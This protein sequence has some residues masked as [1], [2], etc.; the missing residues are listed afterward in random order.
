M[1]R[2][3]AAST[4]IGLAA[5]SA[6]P[7]AAADPGPMYFDEPGHY[8]NDVP[9]MIYDAHLTAPCTNMG[10][11]TFG[12]GPGGEALQCRW[13]PNQWPPVYTGFW[14]ATYDLK[15]V[16]DIGAQC[17]S[18]QSA[19]QAPDGRPLVC[20]GEQGWRAGIYNREG[21]TPIN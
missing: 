4:L 20:M 15:G 7:V 19:A 16:Q 21:F 3:I 18:P 12:R 2:E 9:G 5:L 8:A 17:P 1:I 6:A 10:R 13:I 14:Q 11:F